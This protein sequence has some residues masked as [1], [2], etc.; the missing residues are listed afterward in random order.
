MS[1]KGYIFVT[2]RFLG[3]WREN[4]IFHAIFF[5]DLGIS[6]CISF[7]K[8]SNKLECHFWGVVSNIQSGGHHHQF[9]AKRT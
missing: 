4:A 5:K 6:I 2:S 7:N 1:K 9:L 8:K 3:L